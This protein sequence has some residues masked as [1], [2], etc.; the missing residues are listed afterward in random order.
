MSALEPWEVKAHAVIARLCHASWLQA[1]TSPAGKRY[2][3]HRPYSV[4]SAAAELV[5]CLGMHDRAAAEE[6]AK[7]IFLFNYEVNKVQL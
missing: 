1:N 7:A 5:E 4:P 2:I 6:R 3:K